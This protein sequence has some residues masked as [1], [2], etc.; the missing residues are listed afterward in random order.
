MS[1]PEN[2]KNQ[3][4]MNTFTKYLLG[5]IASCHIFF[6]VFFFYHYLC[7]GVCCYFFHR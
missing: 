5:F 6:L 7:S 4:G 3:G 2:W 1:V